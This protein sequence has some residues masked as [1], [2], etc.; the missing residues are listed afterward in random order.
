MTKLNI[1]VFKVVMTMDLLASVALGYMHMCGPA[2]ILITSMHKCG[3]TNI[4]SM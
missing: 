4:S 1:I 3:P 2:V